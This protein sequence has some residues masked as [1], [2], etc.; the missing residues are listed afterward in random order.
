[1][2][3]K[4]TDEAGRKWRIALLPVAVENDEADE[5]M[6][7]RYTP[8]DEALEERDIRVVGPVMEELPDLDPEELA[9]GLEAAA[10]EL[11]YLFLDRD[12][13][14]WWVQTAAED[15]TADGAAITFAR[16]TDELRH[17]GPLP[18][19]AEELTEDEL[20]ELLD[21]TLGRVIG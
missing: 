8:E 9:L 14:L 13:R 10:N 1:M 20:Q 6:V 18:S 19:P 16:H 11:G 12:E 5:E 7:I 2:T 21:E 3:R 4:L 15:P 17:P